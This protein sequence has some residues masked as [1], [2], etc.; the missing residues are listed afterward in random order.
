MSYAS[1][2]NASTIPQNQEKTKTQREGDSEA[3]TE[4]LDP[5]VQIM[6]CSIYQISS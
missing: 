4:R 2:T 3:S 6:L 1:F 5:T